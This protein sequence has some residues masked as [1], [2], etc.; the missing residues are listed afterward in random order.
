MIAT[1]MVVV[2]IPAGVA[3]YPNIR[4]NNDLTSE[5]Q[6]EQ[7]IIANP[8]NPDNIVAVWRD[9]RLGYRQV[10]IGTSF[11]GG[12][13]WTQQLLQ[14][15]NYI[16]QS[17]PGVTVDSQGN[18]YVVFL[19]YESTSLPN[20]LYVQKSTDGGLTWGA[21]VEVVNGVP[22]VFEDKEL[23]AC[24]RTGSPYDGNLYVVWARFYDITIMC[25][26]SV[27]GGQSF[28]SPLTLGGGYVQWPLAAVGP[29]G[30][31]Y[32]AWVSDPGG[33]RICRSDNGGAS[34]TSHVPIDT[35]ATILADYIN[36]DITVFSYPAMDVDISDGPHSGRVHVAYMDDT[37]SNGMD[38]FYKFSDDGGV[39]WSTR[40]RL[41]DDPTGVDID[42]FH[43][44]L[45][46][47]PDTGDVAVMFYDRRLDPGNLWMDVYWTH[48]SD[49]G[50]TWSPNERITT[51]SSD[52]TAG[53]D[54]LRDRFSKI[55]DRFSN[56]AGLIGEYNGMCASGTGW[57]M[58][59]TDT[60]GGDQDTYTAP[61]DFEEPCIN[62]GDVT[63]DGEITAGDAQLAFLIALGSYTPSY[64]EECAADCNGDEEI[65][66]GD[67]QLIFLTAL[68]SGSCM[69]PL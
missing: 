36:G 13:T 58:V 39:T 60:R 22:N 33:L 30:E 20:G 37:A 6:N 42:Q 66:A 2:W 59:W 53:S 19:S 25:S 55:G 10:G 32:V 34:F 49:G 50:A 41:N 16:W 27:N 57:N 21:S 47:N 65:T 11:D 31:V 44:W 24:D 1:A 35:S 28:E 8:L 63:L 62:D 15:P 29:S 56:R 9:F 18:F 4:L 17:D 68:G 64:E 3:D 38:L 48:S 46:V 51:V 7:Q 12:Y 67:A 52:P 45:A 23:M 40:V 69:D 26:R 61:L 54:F 5:I 14:D 43:P